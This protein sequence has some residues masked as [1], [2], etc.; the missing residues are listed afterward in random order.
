VIHR[1]GNPPTPGAYRIAELV[2]SRLLVDK[3]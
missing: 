1:P 3:V 2:G